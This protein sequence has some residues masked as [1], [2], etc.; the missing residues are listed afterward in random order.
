ML[1]AK[2]GEKTGDKPTRGRPKKSPQAAPTTPNQSTLSTSMQ[3]T[4]VPRRVRITKSKEEVFLENVL[5]LKHTLEQNFVQ[6]SKMLAEVYSHRYYRAW[7]Y[8]NFRTYAEQ[9]LSWNFKHAYNY[10]AVGLTVEQFKI[11]DATAV[12]IGKS[13]M[14]LLSAYSGIQG[15]TQKHVLAA[16]DTALESK[17]YAD[18]LEWVKLAR[19]SFLIEINKDKPAPAALPMPT[20]TY[21]LKMPA[22]EAEW[23]SRIISAAKN[24]LAQNS[25]SDVSSITDETVLHTILEEWA[26]L[27]G[28]TINGPNEPYGT[29]EQVNDTETDTISIELNDESDPKGPEST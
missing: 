2:K 19:N 6:F 4:R 29:T 14:Y 16:I 15:I 21:K 11:E 28:L 9:E 25:Q 24:T 10:V 7:G 17:T 20:V 18:F 22:P 8:A 26:A 13:K 27:K 23:V 12:K 3:A 1:A 5:K